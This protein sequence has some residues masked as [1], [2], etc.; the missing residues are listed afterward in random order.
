MKEQFMAIFLTVS[1]LR[2]DS[3]FLILS[4]FFHASLS[5][6]LSVRLSL[7]NPGCSSLLSGKLMC[8][9]GIFFFINKRHVNLQDINQFYVHLGQSAFLRWR[10]G[11]IK[12]DFSGMAV[13]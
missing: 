13:V 10:G 1:S 11:G 6:C 12:V 7:C 4:M 5:N 3:F 9:Q 8:V 2:E